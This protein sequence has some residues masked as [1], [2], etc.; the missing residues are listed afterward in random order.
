MRGGARP[1]AWGKVMT[2]PGPLPTPPNPWTHAPKTISGWG[3]AALVLLSVAATA[4]SLFNGNIPALVI[5]L[6]VMFG[7][8]VA[9]FALD[10]ITLATRGFWQRFG[11]VLSVV[12]IGAITL[13][14]VEILLYIGTSY[15]PWLDIWFRPGYRVDPPAGIELRPGARASHSSFAGRGLSIPRRPTPEIPSIHVVR[16]KRGTACQMGGEHPRGTTQD[17]STSV[18]VTWSPNVQAGTKVEISIRK[19]GE[20]GEFP[21]P[22]LSVPGEQGTARISGL[23]PGTVYELKLVNILHARVS[24]ARTGLVATDADLKPLGRLLTGTDDVWDSGYGQWSAYYTG[25]LDKRGRPEADFGSMIF[26]TWGDEAARHNPACWIY[27]GAFH[28]GRPHGRGTLSTMPEDCEGVQCG[29]TCAGTFNNSKVETAHCTLFLRFVE[30]PD[31]GSRQILYGGPNRYVGDVKGGGSSARL[32]P[33]SV[34]FSGQGTLA[35]SDRGV[36]GTVVDPYADT[37][38]GKWQDGV[39]IEGEKQTDGRISSVGTNGSSFDVVSTKC[40]LQAISKRKGNVVGPAALASCSRLEIGDFVGREGPLTG[41]SIDAADGMLRSEWHERNK[42]DRVKATP[43]PT[44]PACMTEETFGLHEPPIPADGDWKLDCSEQTS[45]CQIAAPAAGIAFDVK[46]REGDVPEV[47]VRAVD[48]VKARAQLNVDG[49]SI[50]IPSVSAHDN[51][52][53]YYLVARLC[54]GKSA[55]N[56][57]LGRSVP[58]QQ[59]CSLAAVAFAR[60]YACERS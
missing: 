33:F 31:S 34:S 30:Y 44:K 16:Y 39:L 17:R 15:P 47:S 18:T 10:K 2:N 50:E 41:F 21:P 40:I 19:I 35:A 52:A 3:Y 56:M 9:L 8:F 11:K 7:F 1:P 57:S 20:S 59:F 54:G 42:K 4:T 36:P 22:A 6:V 48:D 14:F 27:E 55:E 37:Y 51:G 23:M 25:A 58:L 60:I 53:G 13:L 49:E 28:D 43:L 24:D 26:E 45:S 46:R 12:V 32:G 29:S 38:A 5:T